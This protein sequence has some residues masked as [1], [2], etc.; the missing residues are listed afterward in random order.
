MSA[1]PAVNFID[2]FGGGAGEK[3]AGGWR[4]HH[5]DDDEML[6]AQE[7]NVVDEFRAEHR[8]VERRQE[9]EE[10]ATT[11]PRADESEE[12]LEI[13]RHDLRLQGMKRVAANVVMRLAI[14]RPDESLD[15][16][17]ERE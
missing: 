14:A 8:I 12:V 7:I 16:I 9:H 10:R 5:V 15:S 2:A 11:K 1:E 4:L 6:A 17:A 13:R 3:R